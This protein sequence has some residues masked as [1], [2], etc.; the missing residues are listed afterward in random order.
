MPRVLIQIGAFLLQI[1]NNHIT[2]KHGKSL[3][4]MNEE[5]KAY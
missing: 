4:T 5:S 3:L 2:I 1:G